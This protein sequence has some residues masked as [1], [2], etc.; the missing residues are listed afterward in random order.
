[1]S[2]IIELAQ[3]RPNNQKCPFKNIL[4]KMKAE[5]TTN[6]FKTCKIVKEWV[7]YT[8]NVKNLQ[9]CLSVLRKRPVLKNKVIS[10]KMYHLHMS[11]DIHSR[12]A[13][14]QHFQSWCIFWWLHQ[15]LQFSHHWHHLWSHHLWWISSCHLQTYPKPISESRTERPTISSNRESTG[16]NCEYHSYHLRS[17]FLWSSKVDWSISSSDHPMLHANIQCFFLKTEHEQIR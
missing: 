14:D 12:S 9:I 8:D 1:M 11:K 17:A 3:L 15:Y 7:E 16:S 10:S 13:S 5:Q 2:L 4:V 6:K